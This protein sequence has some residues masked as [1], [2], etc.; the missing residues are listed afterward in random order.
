[1]NNYAALPWKPYE[2]TDYTD[3]DGNR[4]FVRMTVQ[5]AMGHRT[6]DVYTFVRAHRGHLLAFK[7]EQRMAQPFAFS[8][9]DYFP[10]TKKAIPGGLKLCRADVNDYK[11]ILAGKLAIAPADPGA[12]HYNSETTDIWLRMLTVEY[13]DEKTGLWDCP[14]GNANHGWDCSV[15]ALVAADVIGVRYWS[16]P[17]ARPAKPV[18]KAAPAINP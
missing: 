3:A 8:Q 5:D 9:V 10:G 18:K 16:R 15:Y 12:W 4:Y 6:D 2:I 11:N 14:D 17:E 13:I 7:G 1:M